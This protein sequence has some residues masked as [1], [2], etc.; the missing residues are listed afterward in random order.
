MASHER[1]Q[2]AF[3]IASEGKEPGH[4]TELRAPCPTRV[5][6]VRTASNELSPGLAIE[7]GGNSE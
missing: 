2:L 3:V 6:E 7:P 5:A 1:R 4:V